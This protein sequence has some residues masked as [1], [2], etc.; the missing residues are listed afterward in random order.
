[1]EMTLSLTAGNR[2]FFVL[3]V[4]NYFFLLEVDLGSFLKEI[5]VEFDF[6]EKIS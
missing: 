3:M 4:L 2:I 1:M 5:C 6:K